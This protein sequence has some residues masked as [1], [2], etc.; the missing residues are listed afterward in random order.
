MFKQLDPDFT[1]AYDDTE[2][3][4]PVVL[5]HAFPL[6]HSMWR[7]Q[8]KALRADYRVIAPDLR[9][10][11]GTSFFRGAPS[12]EGMAD[13][14]ALLL[15]ALRVDEP[16]VLCGLSMGGYAALAFAHKYPQRLRALILADTRAE[17]DGE[18]AKANRAALIEFAQNHSMPEIVEKVLPNLVAQTTASPGNKVIEEIH[19]IASDNSTD[20]V[21]EALQAMRDRPDATDWLAQIAVPTLLIFGEKDALAPSH[22]IETLR[23]GLPN[24]RLETIAGAGHLSN[25]EAPDKFNR[26]LL[27]FLHELD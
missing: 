8:I 16:I 15:D 10:F 13:D 12:V 21:V 17:A 5:L 7:A 14:L 22:V 26:V 24:A 9:G 3:G 23:N 4:A 1:V 11:G 2:N 20:A 18:E 27:E 6:N 19:R 25:L